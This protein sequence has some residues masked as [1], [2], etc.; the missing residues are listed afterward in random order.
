[1]IKPQKNKAPGVDTIHPRMI[2]YLPPETLK[3][4]LD[5]KIWG[6]REIPNTWKYATITPLLKEEKTQ[7]MLG[8]TDQ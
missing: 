2:K 5:N 8:A 3:Y 4:L 1:M 7:K 6:E